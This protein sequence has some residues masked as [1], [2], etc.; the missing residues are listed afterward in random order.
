MRHWVSISFHVT[1]IIVE[2]CDVLALSGRDRRTMMCKKQ[3]KLI[4]DVGLKVTDSL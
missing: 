1:I 3:N 2:D 4:V